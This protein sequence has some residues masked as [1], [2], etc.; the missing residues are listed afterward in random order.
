MVHD[1][2]ITVSYVLYH[3]T[4]EYIHLYEERSQVSS[5]LYVYGFF[6]F[7]SSSEEKDGKTESKDEKG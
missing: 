4:H 6:F 3:K 7:V 2:L 5:L 1:G